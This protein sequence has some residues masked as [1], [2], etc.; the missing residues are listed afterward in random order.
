MKGNY[1]LAKR[2]SFA[3]PVAHRAACSSWSTRT[4]TNTHAHTYELV[5]TTHT[6]THSLDESFATHGSHVTGRVCA[7]SR[8][9]QSPLQLDGG[10]PGWCGVSV[11]HTTIVDHKYGVASINETTLEPTSIH[12]IHSSTPSLHPSTPTI[13][14]PRDNAEREQLVLNKEINRWANPTE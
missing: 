9:Q 13:H 8:F 7:A 11:H 3:A 2:A 10:C 6:H 14:P 4:N 12:P 1:G 5:Q